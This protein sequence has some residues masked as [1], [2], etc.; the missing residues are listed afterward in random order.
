[1]H[2]ASANTYDIEMKIDEDAELSGCAERIGF[3][4]TGE[5]SC[6]RCCTSFVI[7]ASQAPVEPPGLRIRIGTGVIAK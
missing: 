1:M 4:G 6:G 5:E 7:L 3:S 2:I